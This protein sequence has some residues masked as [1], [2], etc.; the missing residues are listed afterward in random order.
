MT[1]IEFGKRDLKINFYILTLFGILMVL[2]VF[3]TIFYTRLISLKHDF[4]DN[5]NLLAKLQVEVAELESSLNAIKNSAYD[6]NFIQTTGLI[7]DKNP[8]YF[9]S[10]GIISNANN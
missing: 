10:L 2:V 4:L 9:S 5:Q 1:V 7:I 8:S 6:P 3:G